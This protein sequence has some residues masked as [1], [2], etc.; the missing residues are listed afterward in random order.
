MDADSR[1]VIRIANFN[2]IKK[3]NIM[4]INFENTFL[5][6]DLWKVGL[7]IKNFLR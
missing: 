6:R 7:C 2:L 5:Q 4:R 3:I 1:V